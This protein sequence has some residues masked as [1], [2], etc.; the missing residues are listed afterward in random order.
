MHTNDL[1][2]H[3]VLVPEIMS[4][5]DWSPRFSKF[6][7][8]QIFAGKVEQ[9][10]KA[11]MS[12]VKPQNSAVKSLSLEEASDSDSDL[13]SSWSEYVF[14]DII[15]DLSTYM[16]S[17]AD[18]SPSLDHPATDKV[19]T[20]DVNNSL[21]D[22]LWAVSQPAWPFVSIIR[23]RFPSLDAG[24]ARKLGEGNWQRRERLRVKFASADSSI[25]DTIVNPRHGVVE[26]QQTIGSTVRSSISLSKRFQSI[27]I[28]SQ[29]SEPS[30]FDSMSL[31]VTDARRVRP[32]ESVISFAS[33]VAEGMEHGQRRVPNLPEDHEYGSRFQCQI[34]GQ[35]LTGIRHRAGWEYVCSVLSVAIADQLKGTANI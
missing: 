19:F 22:E 4:E 33:S 7:D 32:A 25:G 18:L 30:I 5:F 20:E 28:S 23:D 12:D 2:L 34:C 15:E 10:A 3:L 14:D 11:A 9:I 27:T 29:F 17:L 8:L 1:R 16:E 6:T 26:D 21:I 35:I 13:E 31:S 24:I